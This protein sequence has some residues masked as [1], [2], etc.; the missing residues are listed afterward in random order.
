MSS[1]VSAENVNVN[2]FPRVGGYGSGRCGTVLVEVG[3]YGASCEVIHLP[4]PTPQ[5]AEILCGWTQRGAD[6]RSRKEVALAPRVVATLRAAL[7]GAGAELGRSLNTALHAAAPTAAG[8]PRTAAPAPVVRQPLAYPPPET[9]AR[10]PPRAQV[11]V[12]IAEAELGGRGGTV[13][14]G[15]Q[16]QQDLRPVERGAPHEG[17]AVRG[18]LHPRRCA[19]RRRLRTRG[20]EGG[21][22]RGRGRMRV[23]VG[24]CVWVGGRG[25]G[26]IRRGRRGE[27]A[28][29]DTDPAE[30]RA[31]PRHAA[32]P[33]CVP[34]ARR[35]SHV[36]AGM[37]GRRGAGAGQTAPGR[38]LP[39]GAC[40]GAGVACC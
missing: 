37:D 12:L 28:I 31:A 38:A 26:E 29:Q 35:E 32:A 20:G 34:A 18:G 22:A 5:I 16:L 30:R 33:R 8:R 24:V 23:G 4:Y 3:R 25:V 7:V 39:P 27:T 19:H 17:P 2:M 6:K 40:W 21:K 9:S 14:E 1:V 10:P 13:V 11:D 15:R 36:V